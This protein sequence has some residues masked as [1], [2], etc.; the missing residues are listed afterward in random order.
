MQRERWLPPSPAGKQVA[1]GDQISM[2]DANPHQWV[3]DA[4]DS[5][6]TAELTT[7][8]RGR[9]ATFPVAAVLDEERGVIV[10]TT[11]V[12]YPA[13][14]NNL[15][16]DSRVGAFFGYAPSS[17]LAD[18]PLV[19]IQGRGRVIDDDFTANFIALARYPRMSKMP[20]SLRRHMSMPLWRRM[21]QAYMTRVII[22]IEPVSLI[23]W[24]DRHCTAPPERLDW[25][26]V[27]G[28]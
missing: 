7:L 27:V 12:A 24:R 9:P 3:I 2:T 22:E 28:A 26:D 6:G 4:I 16:A 19:H 17:A 23:A 5:Y 1:D 11:S 25:H 20:D 15:K 8:A 18:P 21:Y 13:K 10:T 14:V